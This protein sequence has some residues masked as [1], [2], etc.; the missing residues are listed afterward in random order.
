LFGLV[1]NRHFLREGF[2]FGFVDAADGRKIFFVSGGDGGGRGADPGVEW[3]RGVGAGEA[4]AREERD[5][6][7]C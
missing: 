1:Q 4:E 2:V 3:W 7:E 5:E 6:S